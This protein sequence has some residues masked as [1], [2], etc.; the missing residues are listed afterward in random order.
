MGCGLGLV[1]VAVPLL[2]TPAVLRIWLLEVELMFIFLPLMPILLLRP[3]IKYN[4][5]IKPI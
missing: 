2:F 1:K 5:K 3:G 4:E